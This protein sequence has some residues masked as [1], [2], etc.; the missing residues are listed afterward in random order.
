MTPPSKKR[1]SS[2][3]LGS[4]PKVALRGAISYVE[5]VSPKLSVS[6]DIMVEA[7]EP[8]SAQEYEGLEH[9]V[10]S[11]IRVHIHKHE[12]PDVRS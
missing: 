6:R 7:S 11:T 9:N 8:L 5:R 10:S 1:S 3:K 2:C 12:R 4:M